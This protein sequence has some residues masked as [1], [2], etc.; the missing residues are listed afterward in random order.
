MHSQHLALT[1]DTRQR[2]HPHKSPWTPI[3]AWSQLLSAAAQACPFP[4][5]ATT[6][7]ASY[8]AFMCLHCFC[9]PLPHY[10]IYP[11]C[12]Q[13]YSPSFSI[14]ANLI[15]SSSC[16]LEQ[17]PITWSSHLALLS[18]HVLIRDTSGPLAPPSSLQPQVSLPQLIPCPLPTSLPKSL[19]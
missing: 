18:L 16:L 19:T 8:S 17:A 1:F 6:S 15:P 7:Q 13:S 12:F 3:P 10:T 5:S 11:Y 14:S 2:P 4:F 9:L